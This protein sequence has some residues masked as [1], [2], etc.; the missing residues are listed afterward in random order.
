MLLKY[1]NKSISLQAKKLSFFGKGIGLMFRTKETKNLL[2]YFK[3]NVKMAI[4]S[5]FVFFPFLAIWADKEN[6][7]M[8]WKIVLPFTSI[9]KPK[10][11]FRKL[12]EVPLN[13][14][15]I[16]IIRFFVG[17]KDLNIKDYKH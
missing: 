2:F 10:K 17:K 12:I 14:K 4:H 1:K 6:K 16:K 7:V 5:Y 8:E 9:V 13:S 3:K 11:Y 15:N